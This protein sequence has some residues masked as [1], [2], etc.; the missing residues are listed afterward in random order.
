VDS[1]EQSYCGASSYR[2]LR[3]FAVLV[4]CSTMVLLPDK[5]PLPSLLVDPKQLAVP[6]ASTGAGSTHQASKHVPALPLTDAQ[7]LK[8]LAEDKLPGW[9]HE[10]KLRIIYLLLCRYVPRGR[11]RATFL[12]F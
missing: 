4:V 11:Y 8:R 5:V 9:G 1:L 10:T 7:F 6:S 2:V 12:P 3:I